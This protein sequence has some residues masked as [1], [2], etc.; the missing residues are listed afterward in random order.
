MINR[1]RSEVSFNLM[2]FL[3]K[4]FLSALVVVTF[5]IYSVHKSFSGSDQVLALNNVTP[6][7]LQESIVP[8]PLP[9][10]TIAATAAPTEISSPDP[11][12]QSAPK[13]IVHPAQPDPTATNQGVYK[14][15]TY[16]GPEVDAYYGLVQVQVKIQDGSIN[17]V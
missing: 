17:D 14:D 1:H 12:V 2:R 8:T 9:P 5:I 6:A 13:T 3:N 15:G 11:I 10:T 4:F 7:A 16:T